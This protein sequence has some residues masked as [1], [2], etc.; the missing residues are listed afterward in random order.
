MARILAARCHG[1]SHSTRSLGAVVLSPSALDAEFR[2]A[3][4]AVGR[5][6]CLPTW[7]AIGVGWNRRLRRAGRAVIDN[8]GARFRSAD[9]ELSPVYFEVYPEDLYG[10]LVHEAVH[11]GLAIQSRPFGH[12]PEF[13]RA[14]TASG[15][16]LHSRWLPGRVF[17]YRCP[18]CDEVLER[19]RRAAESRWCADCAGAAERDG[20]DPYLPDRALRLVETTFR[21]PEPPERA[22]QPVC[23]SHD[24]KVPEGADCAAS[25][26]ASR[27]PVDRSG[28]GRPRTPGRP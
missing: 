4:E 22:A 27:Y 17:R 15:G 25:K 10:I 1:A 23:E 8:R 5:T 19:R 28:D 7:P 11:V 3:L 14:C 13:R 26:D 9:I 18:V 21:G 16:L 2:K 6:L 24:P 20:L 12:G